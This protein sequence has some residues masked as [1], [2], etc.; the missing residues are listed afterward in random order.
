VVDHG[1]HDV[2]EELGA[3]DPPCVLPLKSL[4]ILAGHVQLLSQ[5]DRHGVEEGPETSRCVGEVRLQD[6]LELAQGLL[7]RVDVVDV[8]K[9]EP[10]LVRQF[11][12]AC[13]VKRASCFLRVKRSSGAAATI[14]PSTTNAAAES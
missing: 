8:L 11:S 5:P 10:S 9:A 3:D 7:V 1:Q 6:P 12:M 14:S 13:C 2:G 4:S